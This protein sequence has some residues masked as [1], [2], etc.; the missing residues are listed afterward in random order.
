MSIY[1]KLTA[2]LSIALIA[3]LGIFGVSSAINAQTQQNEPK[4][5]GKR[6]EKREH[7]EK[8]GETEENEAKEKEDNDGEEADD[9]EQEETEANEQAEQAKLAGQATASKEQAQ[10]I[11]LQ[12]VAGEVIKSELEDEDGAVLWNFEILKSDG[13]VTEAKVDAKTGKFVKA[14]NDDDDEKGEKNEAD[15]QNEAENG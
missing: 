6:Q 3:G 1:K 12:N 7:R 14:E 15:E 11:A 13:K 2:I 4:Q 8:K 9:N 5:E 10:A